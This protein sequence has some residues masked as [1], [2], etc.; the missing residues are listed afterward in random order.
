VDGREFIVEVIDSV[1][2]YLD[3]MKDIF[4][5][6]SIRAML[7]GEGQSALKILINAMHG[8]RWCHFKP[9]RL[10]LGLI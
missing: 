7:K 9:V 2:D 10:N 6:A 3:Y 4:D 5:F 8:G 1:Q